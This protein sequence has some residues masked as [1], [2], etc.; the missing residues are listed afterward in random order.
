MGF[1]L[2]ELL[3]VI[4]IIAVLIGLL[5]PAVQKV[6]DAA[7]RLQC[8]NNLKQIG[9][10]CMT[11]H[12]DYNR[13]PPGI[14]VPVNNG[15][16][17]DTFTTD[18]P[19]DP[20]NP[21]QRKILQPP[22]ANTFGSWFLFILPYVEQN[23]VY[24]QAGAASTNFTQRD[25]S[26]CY[27]SS[28][29]G[30]TVIKTY[31]CPA[32]YVPNQVITY[33]N[34]AFGVNSYFANAGTSSWPLNLASLNGVMYYNSSVGVSSVTDGTT[35]TFLA[36]ERYSLD[37]TYHNDQTLDASRGWAWNNWNSGQ[38]HLGCTQFAINTPASQ[39]SVDWRRVT[40]GSGHTGGA[41]FVMCD[42]SVHFVSQNIN[43]GLLAY[44]S[45]P[46]DGNVASL[47]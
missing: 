24:M 34:Y 40:F 12:N 25:Y 8:Q 39:S 7:A 47:P 26:Y 46:N 31:V 43:I 45:V 15:A 22:I 17:G 29:P 38:D 41:N 1:T 36:G 35:N 27:N 20:L 21:G 16:S 44:L 32:D 33:E 5:L 6:R 13:F 4:A 19:P 28:A 9:L 11:Y 37:P 3:V 23:N 18:W 30:A 42:G 14:C 10:A 2:I